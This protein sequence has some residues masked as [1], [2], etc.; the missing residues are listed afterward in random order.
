VIFPLKGGLLL[1]RGFNA[2]TSGMVSQQRVQEALSENVANV[3]TP[4][5]KAD[6]AVLRAFPEM[7]LQ[8]MGSNEP[9]LGQGPSQT[10]SGETVGSIHTGA[11]VQELI[12]YF[13]Q[14]PIRETG[15]PTDLALVDGELPDENGRLFFTI[16]NEDGDTR[17]TRNGN[18]TVDGEG[19]LTTNEGNYVLDDNANRIQPNGMDFL[20]TSDGEVQADGMNANIAIT[21]I[22]NTDDMVKDENDLFTIEGD[23]NAQDA[24]G[25]DMTFSVMQNTLE[26]S[27]VDAEKTMTDMMSTYRLFEQNQRMLRAYDENMG[28]AV[29]EVGRLG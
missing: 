2:L 21:Y 17:Y 20:V 5:Y 8:K 22:D 9:G 15:Q 24:R 10:R 28:K 6:E 4:G 29:S 16:E 19:F 12:P 25:L 27:N 1:F 11:Y 18:L 26:G 23:A 7:L 3:N 13:D 14:G